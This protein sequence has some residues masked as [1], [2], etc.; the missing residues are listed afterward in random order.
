MA[1][2]KR[3]KMYVRMRG[4]WALTRKGLPRFAE[5]VARHATVG[6]A[7]P[8]GAWVPEDLHRRGVQYY[9]RIS[10]Y[11]PPAVD[12]P[13][14]CFVAEDGASSDTEPKRWH[15]LAPAVRE[16]RIPG[17]HYSAVIGHR[18]T[19]AALLAQSMHQPVGA[20]GGA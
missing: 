10:R 14:T 7:A 13:V 19:L 3:R 17:S 20:L 8:P 16:V 2:A 6:S 4:L 1:W 18:A 9:N 5:A 12:V 15:K 11:V